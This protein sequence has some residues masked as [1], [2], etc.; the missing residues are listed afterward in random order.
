MRRRKEFSAPGILLLVVFAVL[1][2]EVRDP[3]KAAA[4]APGATAVTVSPTGFFRDVAFGDLNH[5]GRLDLVA[6]SSEVTTQPPF[7][8]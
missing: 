5:D 7:R 6:T 2:G 3:R 1:A 8:E 4:A